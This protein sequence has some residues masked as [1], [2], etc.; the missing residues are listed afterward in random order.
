MFLVVD[1][2]WVCWWWHDAVVAACCCC[3]GCLL[4]CRVFVV[5]FKVMVTSRDNAQIRARSTAVATSMVLAYV[6]DFSHVHGVV[7]HCPREYMIES[8]FTREQE[9]DSA[10]SSSI[11]STCCVLW[12]E[13]EIGKGWNGVSH[14]LCH[15]FFRFRA[16]SV[17]EGKRPNGWG[18]FFDQR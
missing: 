13:T 3:C 7:R 16:T 6:R 10:A 4:I 5:A 12:G 8:V 17:A 9:F 1:S 15:C 11:R 18:V 14:I 2:G